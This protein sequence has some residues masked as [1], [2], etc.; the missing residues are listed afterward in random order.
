MITAHLQGGLGN[1]M[2]QYAFGVATAKRLGVELQ[3]DPSSLRNDSMRQYALGLFSGVTEKIVYGT[4]ATIKE[5]GLPYNQSIVDKIKD[6]DVLR[7]YWPTEKYF[8]DI[9]PEI[10][11]RFQPKQALPQ[12][13]TPYAI[14]RIESAGPSST[15]LTIRRTDY[16]EK[17]DFHGVLPISYYRTAIHYLKRHGVDPTIFVF[18][19]EPD[20]CKQN[21][22]LGGLV[23]EVLGTY[24]MTT[25]THLGREDVDLYLMSL[26]QHAITANSSFSMWGA[27]LGEHRHAPGIITAPKQWFTT[28]TVDSRDVVPDRW[29]KL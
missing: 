25:P 11:R 22:D 15:Y 24:D 29:V 16:V 9:A 20:W 28:N 17:Q 13:F 18:S 21:L 2:F 1:Q 10:A 14:R 26:C 3:L 6:G 19:D 8:L 5:D 4:K 23:F 27:W 12:I 7:G